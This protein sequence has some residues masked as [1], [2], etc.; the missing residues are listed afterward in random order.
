M[1][2]N[3]QI[4]EYIQSHPHQFKDEIDK[5]LFRE[6]SLLGGA[7]SAQ[8]S[9][10]YSTARE[11]A[12]KAFEYSY[13]KAEKDLALGWEQI[14]SILYFEREV[15]REFGNEEHSNEEVCKEVLKR[16]KNFKERKGNTDGE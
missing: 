15:L 1:E 11:V 9:M 2:K 13:L 12:E 3:K 14:Y 4:E 10:Q 5:W 16:F 6:F 8:L 7:C